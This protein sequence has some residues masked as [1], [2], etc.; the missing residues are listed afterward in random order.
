[1]GSLATNSQRF[2]FGARTILKPPSLVESAFVA[3]LGAVF[4][5]L[6]AVFPALHAAFSIYRR[7]QRGRGVEGFPI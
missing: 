4:P 2:L 7:D 6:H 3:T 5:A 1:M